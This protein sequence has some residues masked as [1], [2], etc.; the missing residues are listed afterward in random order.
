M[1]RRWMIGIA[2]LLVALS[3]CSPKVKNT[4]TTDSK[5]DETK[6]NHDEEANPAQENAAAQQNADQKAGKTQADIPRAPLDHDVALSLTQTIADAKNEHSIRGLAAGIVRDGAI[7][8]R[9][10]AGTT[11][12]SGQQRITPETLFNVQPAA[13]SGEWETNNGPNRWCVTAEDL[14]NAGVQTIEVLPK[15][16]YAQ[17]HGYMADEEIMEIDPKYIEKKEALWTNLSGM[18]RYLATAQ[19][20]N[21]LQPNILFRDV[22]YEDYKL[23]GSLFCN[24]QSENGYTI[25]ICELPEKHLR[26]LFI[27]NAS[28]VDAEY[29]I[30][31]M[32]TTVT[33]AEYKGL[34]EKVQE[35][36][37]LMHSGSMR[38]NAV[39]MDASPQYD[40]L[41]GTYHNDKYGDLVILKDEN[42]IIAQTEAY[43]SRLGFHSSYDNSMSEEI[44]SK[45]AAEVKKSH[46]EYI[47]VEMDT[48]A[49]VNETLQTEMILFDP[50]V[51]NYTITADTD[52]KAP[53]GAKAKAIYINAKT[54]FDRVEKP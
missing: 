49:L 7:V 24:H 36:D 32:L 46:P 34:P 50:P 15:G 2:G 26:F 3:A 43:R 30:A 1:H 17:P 4:T 8:Y 41:L 9:L 21:N 31:S 54:R 6:A 11:D 19:T 28:P 5:P 10:S 27:A 35:Y 38:D 37:E 13:A 45:E 16:D 53:K 20:L 48:G 52:P 51:A 40:Y 14:R 29:Y 25:T 39:L 44:D 18:M 42:T 23:S 12:M 22:Y 47:L 33:G